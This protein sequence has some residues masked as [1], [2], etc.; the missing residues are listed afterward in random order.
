MNHRHFDYPVISILD[1]LNMVSHPQEEFDEVIQAYIRANSGYLD[2]VVRHIVNPFHN[3]LSVPKEDG[4]M[5]HGFNFEMFDNKLFL[6]RQQPFRNCVY[7][8]DERTGLNLLFNKQ[9]DIQ[10]LSYKTYFFNKDGLQDLRQITDD[11]MQ[12]HNLSKD[13]KLA[14]HVHQPEQIFVFVDRNSIEV[15]NNDV[16]CSVV[17]DLT[18]HDEVFIWND[19]LVIVKLSHERMDIRIHSTTDGKMLDSYYIPFVMDEIMFGCIYDNCLFVSEDNMYVSIINLQTKQVVLRKFVDPFKEGCFEWICDSKGLLYIISEWHISCVQLPKWKDIDR[20]T[21]YET[22]NIHP[23]SDDYVM[24]YYQSGER[25]RRI[26]KY[27]IDMF[28]YFDSQ[29]SFNASSKAENKLYLPHN[30]SIDLFLDIV[31]IISDMSAIYT[32][33]DYLNDMINACDMLRGEYPM[34]IITSY[35]YTVMYPG[36]IDDVMKMIEERYVSDEVKEILVDYLF[37][38]SDSIKDDMYEKIMQSDLDMSIKLM[39]RKKLTYHHQDY[40]VLV[41]IIGDR[42]A[43]NL[44]YVN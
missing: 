17:H 21:C 4:M 9:R 15:I 27:I 5:M 10:D 38:Y 43:L 39:K 40:Q 24:I 16:R 20:L 35:L 42:V 28:D 8:V 34:K 31:E 12:R 7:E 36:C 11:M 33:V 37:F 29:D 22:E 41:K 2:M 44:N 14:C 18:Y 19:N 23:E 6:T 1:Y 30:I 13:H 25:C 3:A 26:P 32:D